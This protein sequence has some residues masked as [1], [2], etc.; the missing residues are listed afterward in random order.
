MQR[1]WGKKKLD[2]NDKLK[3]GH[4]ID[5]HEVTGSM[6]YSKI[7]PSK[8]RCFFSQDHFP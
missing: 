3:K 2:L 7:T 4:G 5:M 1:T 8:V 6:R